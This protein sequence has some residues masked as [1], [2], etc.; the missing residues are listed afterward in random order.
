MIS[1]GY[2]TLIKN[3]LISIPLTLGVLISCS[4]PTSSSPTQVATS[5]NGS[6]KV[7]LTQNVSNAKTLLPGTDMNPA[8]YTISGTGPSSA[9]FTPVT[10]TAASASAT[11]ASLAVGAW[12]ITVQAYNADL[13]PTEIGT[14]S[15]T[16][17]VTSGGTAN[18]SISVQPLSGNGTLTINMTW[19]SGVIASPAVVA[20]L[21]PT[22]GTA[23][24]IKMTFTVNTT[25][26]SYT[27]STI[28]SG[29]YTLAISLNDGSTNVAGKTEMV[30][31][32]SCQTTSGTYNF[33]S[34]NSI[35]GAVNVNITPSLASPFI[36]SIS[37]G[38]STI[39]PG[40]TETLTASVTGS[41][42]GV[43]YA[44]YVNGVSQNTNSATWSGGSSWAKGYYIIDVTVI[45]STGTQA[46]SGTTSI[47]VVDPTTSIVTYN[48]NEAISGNVPVDTN[49]YQ[50]NATVTVSG[51]TG[52]LKKSGYQ[53]AGWMTKLDGTGISYATGA[54]FIM[55]ASN[56]TLYAVWIQNIL[57]FTSSGTSISITG[58]YSAPSGTFAIP[59][60]V[61]GIGDNVFNGCSSLSSITI[62]LSATSI[63]YNAFNGCSGLT[64]ITIP[65]S[66]IN[67]DQA[68]FINCSSLTSV[69]I[70]SSVTSIGQYAFYGCSSL[71]SITIPSSVSSISISSFQ[72]CSS[73]SSITIPSSV[74]SIGDQAFASCT[75]LASIAIPINV[76]SIGEGVF[77]GCSCLTSMTLLA[78]TP[79]ILSTQ[80][81]TGCPA[82]FQIHVPSGSLANYQ[83]AFGWSA[84]SSQIVSP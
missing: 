63:G 62:P 55:G 29:Y 51:N 84:F 83:N 16:A 61:T 19:P 6:I 68:A 3:L 79:P 38:Q 42:S 25:S 5:G 37:G 66:V 57:T 12:T 82:G 14:G 73:L 33:T 22:T 40:A 78:T 28:P 43:S 54:T 34:V 76:T 74:T 17:T 72:A 13:T 77:N 30:R 35:T 56:I 27:S 8:S 58:Y 60:G 70:S 10:V 71:T 45:S 7:S 18:V 1:Q 32:V 11:I 64:S 2:S 69:I 4:T 9:T 75:S 80:V 53:L 31:I 47:S 15:G 20:S 41:P 49:T 59:T 23:I 24:P 26:A 52:N 36:V 65:S 50:L 48:G 39:T 21:T 81:F 67:I 46:G 44:W